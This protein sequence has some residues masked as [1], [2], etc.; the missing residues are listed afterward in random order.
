MTRAQWRIVLCSC[1]YETLCLWACLEM[2]CSKSV[3]IIILIII[4]ITIFDYS[5]SDLSD[6]AILPEDVI[7]FFS[8]DL[9]RQVLHIQ[10]TIDFRRKP[11]LQLQSILSH[12]IN[13]RSSNKKLINYCLPVNPYSLPV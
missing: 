1:H 7:H 4:L 2:R 6:G 13:Y 11:H 10:D 5:H 8:G 9:V 12:V 3:Q